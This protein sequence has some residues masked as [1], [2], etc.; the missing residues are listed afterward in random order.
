MDQRVTGTSPSC[1]GRSSM[2][3]IPTYRHKDHNKQ[4]RECLRLSTEGDQSLPSAM[5]TWAETHA[6]AVLQEVECA[7]RGVCGDSA[8]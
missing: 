1:S 6:Q 7:I 8:E 5:H 3:K 2:R 4:V